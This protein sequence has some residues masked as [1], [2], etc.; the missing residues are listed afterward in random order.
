MKEQ[1]KPRILKLFNSVAQDSNRT[2]PAITH[3]Q[4]NNQI[5]H[6]KLILE[7]QP[8]VSS[9]VK[10]LQQRLELLLLRQLSRYHEIEAENECELS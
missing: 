10:N 8:L 4:S 5:A 9:S 7:Q 6:K 3:T 1:F 2:S